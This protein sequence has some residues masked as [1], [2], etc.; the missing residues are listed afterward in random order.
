MRSNL[1]Y[2]VLLFFLPFF[3]RFIRDGGFFSFSA[4]FMATFRIE[5]LF[6]SSLCYFHP[7]HVSFGRAFLFFS[8]F[9]RAFYYGR[10]F[11]FYRCTIELFL[12]VSFLFSFFYV[13]TDDGKFLNFL[14]R[15]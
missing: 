5:N 1:S 7:F 9:L 15:K 13:Y 3:R 6:F 14:N 10:N 8:P 12:A 11:P 4:F 2:G